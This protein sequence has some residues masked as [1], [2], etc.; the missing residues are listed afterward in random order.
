MLFAEGENRWVRHGWENDKADVRPA[1]TSLRRHAGAW[2]VVTADQLWKERRRAVR[3]SGPYKDLLKAQRGIEGEAGAGPQRNASGA[4]ELDRQSAMDR[5]VR[6]GLVERLFEAASVWTKVTAARQ[7]TLAAAGRD[8][9]M[10]CELQAVLDVDGEPEL[11]NRAKLHARVTEAAEMYSGRKKRR[12][13]APEGNE[14][15]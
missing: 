12:E 8:T 7:Q 9:G 10:G 2:Y 4:G 13:G 15:R 14:H 1:R 11:E 3:R 6:E 5:I